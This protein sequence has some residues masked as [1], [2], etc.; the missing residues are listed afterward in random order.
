[1]GRVETKAHGWLLIE[2]GRIHRE[3]R[4]KERSEVVN[5]GVTSFKR[6]RNKD[7]LKIK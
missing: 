1:M 6:K 3:E 7:R 2:N 5:L 4:K